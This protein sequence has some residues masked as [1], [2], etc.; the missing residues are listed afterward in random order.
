MPGMKRR[1]TASRR[2]KR[3]GQ[4]FLKAPA[5]QNCPKCNKPVAPHTACSNCG[6]YKGRQVVDVFKKLDKKERKNKEAEL[7]NKE[8]K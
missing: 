8:S 5:V 6:T 1:S 3:R 2:D 4:I 7:A